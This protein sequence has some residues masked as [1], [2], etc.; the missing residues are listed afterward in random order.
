MSEEP[1]VEWMR[2]EQ[3]RDQRMAGAASDLLA[4]LKA[5]HQRALAELADPEDVEEIAQAEAAIR[6]AEG[7]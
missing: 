6:K 2:D 7:R 3:I 5:L 1:F 4:A